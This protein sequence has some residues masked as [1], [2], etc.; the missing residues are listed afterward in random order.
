MPEEDAISLAELY[1]MQN[2]KNKLIP[3]SRFLSTAMVPKATEKYAKKV[4]WEIEVPAKTKGASIESFNIEREAEAEFL[5]QRNS[6]LFVKGGKYE[7]QKK[8]LTLEGRIE[9]A[10]LIDNST[11]NVKIKLGV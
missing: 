7:P 10:D 3:Q 2:L 5:A 1:I 9:Q 8:L 11:N 4:F 6:N